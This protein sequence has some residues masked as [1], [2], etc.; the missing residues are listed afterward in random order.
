MRKI[1]QSQ[2]YFIDRK[3]QLKPSKF[4][5]NANSFVIPTFEKLT[6]Y[7][8]SRWLFQQTNFDILTTHVWHNLTLSEKYLYLKLKF[9][10]I[11]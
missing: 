3:R 8:C 10:N 2:D 4:H 9:E 5:P 7:F 11:F 6:E 1:F